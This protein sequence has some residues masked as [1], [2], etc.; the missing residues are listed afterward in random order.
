[1]LLHPDVDVLEK[2]IL[3]QQNN[4]LALLIS[5]MIFVSR[6]G[7]KN[8]VSALSKILNSSRVYATLTIYYTETFRV[9]FVSK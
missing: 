7:A 4:Y 1:M 2:A 8:R 5:G 6:K 9:R 3:R